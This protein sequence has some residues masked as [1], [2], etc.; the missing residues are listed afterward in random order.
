M[1]TAH[2]PPRSRTGSALFSYGFRPFFLSGAIWSALAAPL[3]IWSLAGGAAMA[4]HRDWHVHEML[5]GVLSAI[6]AGFLT[7]AIPSWT[8]RQPII[9]SKLV[10]LWTLWLAGRLA[11]LGEV[12]IGPIA[13]WIDSAFLVVL[14]AVVWREVSGGKNW[15]NLP[16]CLLVSLL[17]SANIAFHLNAAVDVREFGMRMALAAAVCMLALIGGRITPN[18]STNWLRQRGATKL[19]APFSRLD[20][21][22]LVSTGLAGLAWTVLADHAAAGVLLMAAGGLNL[23]RL[24]RWRGAKTLDEPLLAILHLGYGW[25]A[26]GLILLGAGILAPFAPRAAGIHAL[27]AGAIGVTCLAV[28]CRASR[29]HTGRPLTA[30]TPT[31]TIFAAVNLAALMRVIAPYTPEYQSGLLILAAFF[32]SLAYGGFAVFYGPMLCRR[33]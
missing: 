13:A 27:S 28:M 22:A 17:A 7:T 15:R 31:V 4:G 19:P 16:I 26:L 20:M 5:F 1:S 6:A 21:A 33:P 2:Q 24:S 30:D 11:V 25:L 29:G 9:G 3:W 10:A 23:L 18:F 14:A 8:G 12:L 32:W